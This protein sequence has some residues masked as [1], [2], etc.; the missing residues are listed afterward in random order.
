[1]LL[2]FESL[3]NRDLVGR[4]LE[5]PIQ[6]GEFPVPGGRDTKTLNPAFTFDRI[7]QVQQ[8]T[9]HLGVLLG[10][11]EALNFR[12]PIASVQH[13]RHGHGRQDALLTRCKLPKPLEHGCVLT[14]NCDG[15]A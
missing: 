13:D 6:H 4:S 14:I 15:D 9:L 12:P 11:L 7:Q 10:F 8:H 3:K 2:L 1:M 5:F